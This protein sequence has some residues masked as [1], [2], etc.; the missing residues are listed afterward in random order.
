MTVLT[1]E[2]LV[3]M[4]TINFSA[5]IVGTRYQVDCQF[6]EK[7][8]SYNTSNTKTH[9]LLYSI[10]YRHDRHHHYHQQQ[11]YCMSVGLYFM[12]PS[13]RVHKAILSPVVVLPTCQ[14]SI[15]TK[16]A[17]YFMRLSRLSV[18]LLFLSVWGIFKMVGLMLP[19]NSN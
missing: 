5:F 3:C 15:Y 18:S 4:I 16:L 8:S 14:S 17:S 13:A 10:I 2:C 9:L 6:I 19:D 11:S 12:N 7:A 1:D